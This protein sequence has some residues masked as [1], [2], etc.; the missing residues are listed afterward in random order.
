MS[1]KYRIVDPNI[2]SQLIAKTSAKPN[3]TMLG[4]LKSQALHARKYEDSNTLRLLLP[5]KST[6]LS[7]VMDPKKATED[8]EEAMLL[9]QLLEDSDAL[10]DLA[11]KIASTPDDSAISQPTQFAIIVQNLCANASQHAKYR[12]KIYDMLASDHKSVADF[13]QQILALSRQL[14]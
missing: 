11:L 9:L 7:V 2:L 10:S 3:R 1:E 8:R 12:A 13:A 5:F 14:F 4:I 6:A